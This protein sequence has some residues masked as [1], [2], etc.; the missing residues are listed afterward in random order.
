MFHLHVPSPCSICPSLAPFSLRLVWD[1]PLCVLGS[2]IDGEA[3]AALGFKEAKKS[4]KRKV[5]AV[6]RQYVRRAKT[7]DKTPLMGMRRWSVAAFLLVFC[8]C[9]CF[10]RTTGLV[11]F[12]FFFHHHFFLPSFTLLNLPFHFSFFTSSIS[13]PPS[14][15]FRFLERQTLAFAFSLVLPQKYLSIQ[16]CLQRS[17]ARLSSSTRDRLIHPRLFSPPNRP[18]ALITVAL[19]KLTRTVLSPATTPSNL[20]TV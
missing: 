20:V 17:A 11:V 19:H 14:P 9:A 16:K 15:L 13:L 7:P 12:F 6:Q 2:M 18:L 5:K 4:G 8:F 10:G 3:N 1:A